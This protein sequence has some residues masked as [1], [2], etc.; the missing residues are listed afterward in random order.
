MGKEREDGCRVVDVCI[1]HSVLG[2]GEKDRGSDLRRAEKVPFCARTESRSMRRTLR[3]EGFLLH[4]LLGRP[5][6]EEASVAVRDEF[7]VCMFS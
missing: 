6:S 5:C 1:V 2:F 4:K 3:I 7:E